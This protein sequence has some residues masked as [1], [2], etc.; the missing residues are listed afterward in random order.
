MQLQEALQ[1][2]IAFQRR[3]KGEFFVAWRSPKLLLLAIRVGAR[4]Y[5]LSLPPGDLTNALARWRL[6]PDGW[7]PLLPQQPLTQ[8]RG[9]AER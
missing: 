9:G 5:A 3:G 2:G 7:Q 6:R 1:K 4:D 8:Q